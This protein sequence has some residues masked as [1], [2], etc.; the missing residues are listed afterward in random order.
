M[1]ITQT[2]HVNTPVFTAKA[3]SSIESGNNTLDA[4]SS[5]DT[6]RYSFAGPSQQPVRDFTIDPVTGLISTSKPLNWDITNVYPVCDIK[7]DNFA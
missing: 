3:I 5:S 6:I 4:D 7:C 2:I 1:M